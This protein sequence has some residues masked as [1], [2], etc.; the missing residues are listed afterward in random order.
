MAKREKSSYMIKSV[1]NALDLL[2]ELSNEGGELGVTELSRRL[3]LHKNNI[4]RLLAT[5]ES[6]GYVEQNK[7]TEN[8][9]LGLKSL[10]LG[11]NY[12]R[13]M[14]LIKQVRPILEE[15]VQ[16]CNEN[17]GLGVV[18]QQWVV[19]LDVVEAKR[20]VR[21]ACRAGWRLPVYASAIG[22]VQLAFKSE[23]EIEKSVDWK[24]MKA[25]TPNTITDKE[26]FLKHLEEV[27]E[28]G[29][30]ID[31]EEYEEGV[32]CV[33]V[34]VRDYTQ[35]VVAGISIQAPVFRVPDERIEKEI[36]PLLKEAGVKASQK[37]G[38]GE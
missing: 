34:P 24:N 22:K 9:R 25:F 16:K 21:V 33:A 13:R 6:K 38:Y 15:L 35:R 23:S 18:R 5:L 2:E 26:A 3:N 1:A 32:K 28:R 8:Y 17:A 29:Y 7:E 31:D 37:L 12:L 10:E 36:L 14:S 20:M 19:Y 11:Q 30:A 4:F 27:R